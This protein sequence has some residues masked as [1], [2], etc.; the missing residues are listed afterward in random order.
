MLDMNMTSDVE[1]TLEKITPQKAQEWLDNY[2]TCNRNLRESHVDKIVRDILSGNWKINGDAIRFS[3]KGEL[4]DGQHRLNAIV[5]SGVAIDTIVIRGISEASRQ[6]IDSGIK[7]TSGDNLGLMGIK[8]SNKIAAACRYAIVLKTRQF[9]S[10]FT[11][12]EI[13]DFYNKHSAISEHA[14]KFEKA[15]CGSSSMSI[16]TSYILSLVRPDLVEPFYETWMHGVGEK[17]NPFLML[18][19][20]LIQNSGGKMNM[21]TNLKLQYFGVAISKAVRNEKV[22]LLK[23]S[24]GFTIKGWTD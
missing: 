18:R 16:A 20:K 7:R 22:L 13:I 9:S 21:R 1:V 19:E 17:N 10:S 15:I 23:A 14:G 11:T 2:N 8:N 12:S 24:T 6:T 5:R 3:V 4:L